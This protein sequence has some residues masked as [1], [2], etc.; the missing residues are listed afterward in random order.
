MIN[1]EKPI[2]LVSF[3]NNQ[4]TPPLATQ[5]KNIIPTTKEQII[6]G[7]SGY[8]LSKVVVSA[9][10]K[11]IDTNIQPNNIK[12]GVTILGVEGNVAPD[13]PDQSK[14]VNPTTS[15]QLITADIGYELAQV[16][17]NAV[18]SD[19]D[20]NIQSGNIKQ[21]ITI[22]GVNGSL[23]P[24][25]PDQTKIVTPTTEEQIVTADS[26]FELAS[27]TVNAV[28]S[29]IDE[30]IV[31]ENIKEGVDILGVSGTFVGEGGGDS[32][33]QYLVQVIDY[34]GTVLKSDHLDTGAT[35]T[36]PDAPTNHSKLVFQEWS[37]PV[38]ITN[39]SI[40]VGNSDITIGATYKTASGLTEIDIVLTKVTG[41]S[42]TCNM[43]GNKNWGDGT[44]DSATTHT[45][46]DY[47]SYTITCDG[48]SIPAGSSSSS[49]MFSSSRSSP[50]Y[51]C[52]EIR[53]GDSVTSIGDYAFQAC[54]S[55]TSVTIPDSVT[56]IRDYAFQYCYSLTSVTIPDSVTSIR[57]YAFSYC[58]SLTS[59]TIPDSVTSIRDYAFRYCYSLTSV[60][61]PDSVTSIRAYA[62]ATCGALTSVTI[63]DSV[64]SIG[65]YAFAS[66]DALTSVTIPDSVTSIGYAFQACYSLTSV[67]IPD[68]VTN[69]R[70][71]AFASCYSIIKYDFTSATSIPT[72]S[73]TNAFSSINGICKIY[74]PDALYD[75]WIVATNWPIYADYIY[76][77]SEME[78]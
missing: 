27:V 58:Y 42:V 46:T 38:A 56:S 21:G 9:V 44:T 11:D 53:V 77:A 70:T 36:L 4:N 7:D 15:Q 40:T 29:E 25:K 41:L 28:T 24:D 75:D 5:E 76:K 50:N 8:N 23:I 18:T 73:N 57:T 33:G 64:T 49:G 26:G 69:I 32:G 65:D 3:N 1:T 51:Y 6:T 14:I 54:F 52:T 19:I 16:T 67:T 17:V 12:Q 68:S 78:D 35:F 60:T 62:F 45:Y 39:N 30:N 31:P 13:K 59:V 71:S 20:D 66:C 61:I 34:D 43:V 72:L 74:V 55:L 2:S 22:L 47:G 37:S 48:I 10:T 63:P